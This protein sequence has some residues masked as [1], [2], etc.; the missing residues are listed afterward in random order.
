MA[1]FT[2]P[3]LVAFNNAA[4][5]RY[6][7]ALVEAKAAGRVSPPLR[8]IMNYY[9]SKMYV[10]MSLVNG[11]VL[12][13]NNTNHK[14][15]IM[16]KYTAYFTAK[17]IKTGNPLHEDSINVMSKETAEQEC[18]EIVQYFN[19]TI[20]P[21]E[22]EREFVKLNRIEEKEVPDPIDDEFDAD[23]TEF[24][25]DTLEMDDHWED[26]DFDDDFDL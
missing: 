19:N 18:K 4:V 7:S 1:E 17:E 5:E 8:E 24:G 20:K 26:E 22:S 9:N 12:K 6:E 10:H 16:K 15:A 21:G 2:L 13:E 11:N 23:F 25:S 14:K 3:E